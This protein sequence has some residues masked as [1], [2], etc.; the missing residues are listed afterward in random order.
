MTIFRIICSTAAL[1]LL[2]SCG[3]QTSGGPAS[4]T[5]RLA[6]LEQLLDKR[7]IGPNGDYWLVKTTHLGTDAVGLVFGVPD[8]GQF[9]QELADA[10]NE[11]YPGAQVSCR[12]VQWK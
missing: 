7:S 9:C 6:E 5:E 10:Q 2:A 1:L 3:T 8:N 4:Y 11:L 12:R